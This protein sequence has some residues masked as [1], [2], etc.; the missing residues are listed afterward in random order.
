MRKLEVNSHSVCLELYEPA[1]QHSSVF[2]SMKSPNGKIISGEAH[3]SF[4]VPDGGNDSGADA[5]V[6]VSFH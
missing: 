6:D 4:N 3:P 2:E 1:S 5:N